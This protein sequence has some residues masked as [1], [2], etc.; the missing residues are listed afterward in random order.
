MDCSVPWPIQAREQ[1]SVSEG[2]S[3]NVNKCQ[4]CFVSKFFQT[5]V[6][7]HAKHISIT[8]AQA[9]RHKHLSVLKNLTTVVK[10]INSFITY[11]HWWKYKVILSHVLYRNIFLMPTF[12][13]QFRLYLSTSHFLQMYLQA[14]RE[15]LLPAN[16]YL[17]QWYTLT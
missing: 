2:V 11:W 16:K 4:L 10:V 15:R 14:D 7:K 3:T 8:S 9:Y 5:N 12:G 6:H 1:L 17:V 13:R